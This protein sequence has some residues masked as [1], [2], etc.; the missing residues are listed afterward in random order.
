MCL[1]CVCVCC[2]L[3][4]TI[5]FIPF[6]L[7]FH[8]MNRLGIVFSVS[9]LFVFSGSFEFTLFCLFWTYISL[10]WLPQISFP[11]HSNIQAQISRVCVIYKI[12]FDSIFRDNH[13]NIPSFGPI[14]ITHL[15][16]LRIYVLQ[17]FCLKMV[18]EFFPKEWLWIKNCHQ[19][20][21]LGLI[22]LRTLV[23]FVLLTRTTLGGYFFVVAAV[24]VFVFVFVSV[25]VFVFVF[26]LLRISVFGT[27]WS[28]PPS[29]YNIIFQKPWPKALVD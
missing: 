27:Q 12:R 9:E 24:F 10:V 29:P 23:S 14:S 17:V 21:L 28:S 3:R 19:V 13:N 2:K 4:T 5:L 20:G 11:L 25:F 22:S 1:R 8:L 6:L 16:P 15:T 7:G 18:L 26:V